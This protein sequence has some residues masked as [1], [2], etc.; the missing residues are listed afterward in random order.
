MCAASLRSLFV[1]VSLTNKKSSGEATMLSVPLNAE[2]LRKRAMQCRHLADGIQDVQIKARLLGIAT[3]YEQ[4]AEREVR[5]K[6]PET[7][8]DLAE[9]IAQRPRLMYRRRLSRLGDPNR[10]INSGSR[11]RL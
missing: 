7:P 4:M 10:S 3:E 6:Q 8:I 2:L 9:R 5:Q 11:S 1:S